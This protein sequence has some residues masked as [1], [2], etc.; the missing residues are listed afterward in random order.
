M[1][2]EEIAKIIVTEAENETE[3]CYEYIVSR[4]LDFRNFGDKC[5][6]EDF[7][8]K[9]QSSKGG[10]NLD[11]PYG[12][13]TDLANTL[14][15]WL[16]YTQYVKR[17]SGRLYI[18][19]DKR[20][21]VFE[22][23]NSMGPF[24]DRPEQQEYFQRKYGVDPKHRK[25]NRDL[26]N[27]RTI[28]PRIIAQQK[29]KQAY[30]VESLKRPLTK[31]DNRLID[32]IVL[33]TGIDRKLTE[34]I[35]IETYPKGS[36]SSFMTKYFE[37]AFKGRDEATE[38][39]KATVELFESVFGFECK[40]VGPI[41]LTPDVLLV[42]E[43]AGFQAI[44]DNKAYRKYSISNDHHNRMVY[45]YL[46]NVSRYSD[47]SLPMGFFTYIA[48]GFSDSISGQI[49]SIYEA[50]NVPGSAISVSNIIKLV[51]HNEVDCYSHDRLRSI[52][53]VNR[54]IFMNDL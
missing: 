9:Y 48:G 16:E 38:F 54:Q 17:D 22:R 1:T 42:S 52:F 39:E 50:T 43:E 23:L 12:H 14:V 24:I 47:S 33:Q 3:R 46:K 41:G 19:E 10:I 44:I 6:D 7:L 20:T 27:A 36:V 4:I 32:Y 49:S 26:T 51:E 2:E 25:D 28:T 11:N 35:L 13:L 8:F 40:H 15:N 21:E 5:L 30:I 34:E 31:I 37:M 29:I 53:S 18:L 45:N